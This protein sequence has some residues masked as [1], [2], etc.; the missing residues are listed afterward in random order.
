MLLA[1]KMTR[2]TLILF[3]LSLVSCADKQNPYKDL[4]LPDNKDYNQVIFEIIKQ[5]T[6]ELFKTKFISSD[7]FKLKVDSTRSR[8]E[9]V[10]K[11]TLIYTTRFQIQMIS[12][13]TYFMQDSLYFRFQN[14]SAKQIGIDTSISAFAKLMTKDSL[15]ENKSKKYFGYY[16]FSLPVFNK[17]ITRA[18]VHS[19]YICSKC[20]HGN[21]YFLEK[22]NNKWTI[23]EKILNWTN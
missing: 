5:D 16:Q 6:L 19:D 14:D 15:A 7:L 12:D 8:I 22:K 20:G 1:I 2:L 3:T 17:A 21:I 23:I 9:V 4:R 18:Y 13:S 11:Q 10:E